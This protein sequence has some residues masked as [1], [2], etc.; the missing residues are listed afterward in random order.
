MAEKNT[1]KTSVEAVLAEFE[2]CHPTLSAFCV[3]TKALI[4]VSLEDAG[5]RY[6]SV[7]AR[8]K[9]KKKLRKKYL[10]PAKDYNKLDD[11]TDLAGL[12][13][14]TYYDDEVDRVA[15]LIEKEFK[16]DE[17]ESVDK[18]DTDPDRFGYRAVNFICGHL[19]RRTSDVEYKH[20]SGIRCE[21]QITSILGHAWAE[22]EHEWYDLKEAY[23]KSI[24]RRFSRIAALFEI[25]GEE[26]VDIRKRRL[27]YEKSV[28]LQVE[29]KL[30]NIPLDAVSLRSFID[31]E[32]LVGEINRAIAS[33]LGVSLVK[34]LS[35]SVMESRSK[36][37]NIIGIATLEELREALEIY[38][39]FLPEFMTR[40]A[41][42]AWPNSPKGGE[43]DRSLCVY[44]LCLLLAA[45][46]G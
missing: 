4:E 2:L 5:I 41:T 25:A 10:D 8:V 16:I 13:I 7:Q 14:I 17:K 46:G 11:I 30:P 1:S 38:G 36:S 28:S 6:Q 23:P 9:T 26:F 18:R 43:A 12:R 24:K 42:E 35:D 44:N 15:E 27:D 37:A 40:F 45:R 3:R 20:F 33:A 19:D 39:N 22:I 31:Q 21:I 34:P 32:P 29:A